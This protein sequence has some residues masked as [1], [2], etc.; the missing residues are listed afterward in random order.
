CVELDDEVPWASSQ[1]YQLSPFSEDENTEVVERENEEEDLLTEDATSEEDLFP[2]V[3]SRPMKSVLSVEMD[4]DVPWATEEEYCQPSPF[5]QDENTEDV[6][7]D[8]EEQQAAIPTP[9]APLVP[10]PEPIEL[11]EAHERLAMDQEPP[12]Q[13]VFRPEMMGL[14]VDLEDGVPWASPEEYHIPGPFSQE[15]KRERE[16]VPE[17]QAEEQPRR[18][19]PAPVA[20]LIP[21]REV[22]ELSE[23]D[24]IPYIYEGKEENPWL[25]TPPEEAPTD[26]QP[27]PALDSPDSLPLIYAEK[28]DNSRPIIRCNFQFLAVFY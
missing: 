26:S 27:Q 20:P 11:G 14:F 24:T 28:W 13:Q 9:A 23:E 19:V 2:D 10:K 22:I 3:V 7:G 8:Q 21:K 4:D 5:S 12:F 16:E 25:A 15:V 18:Q 1:D 6:R 17:E